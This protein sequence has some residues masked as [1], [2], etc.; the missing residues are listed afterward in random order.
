M[1]TSTSSRN[2]QKIAKLPEQIDVSLIK[3]SAI[4]YNNT[5]KYSLLSY[6][7]GTRRDNLFIQTPL[8][9][10]VF[11]VEHGREFGEYYFQIPSD[12]AGTNFLNLI[13]DLEQR[14]IS[15]AFENKSNWFQNKENIKFRS[16][17]K[18]V[19]SDSID[20][21]ANKVIKFRIPYNIK[22]KR[23]H[24]DTLDNMN[25]TDFENISIKNLDGG[26][27]RIIINI[28]AIWFTDD[29]FGLYIRPIYVEEIKLCEYQFQEQ[30]NVLFLDTEMFPKDNIVKHDVTALNNIVKSSVESL[31]KPKEKEADVNQTFL[32]NNTQENVTYDNHKKDSPKYK[33]DEKNSGSSSMG[34]R[35]RNKELKES[36]EPKEPK[37]SK[38]SKEP[39]EPK[40]VSPTATENTEFF[41]KVLSEQK[42]NNINFNSNVTRAT[43]LDSTNI[44]NGNNSDTSDELNLYDNE[45]GDDEDI[46]D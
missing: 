14:L 43:D 3:T 41:P 12:T 32:Q 42:P 15:L 26:Q 35:L 2:K 19:Q 36:K 9:E 4:M 13:N 18:N 20:N 44:E 38:E 23:L 8:F 7:D 27:V 30:D 16:S 6:G 11:D 29:M 45:D 34:R 28:N 37:E 33:K 46:S 10:N 21:G 1:E 40:K 17:I 5:K 31:S 22:T 39:K 25:T 24:I